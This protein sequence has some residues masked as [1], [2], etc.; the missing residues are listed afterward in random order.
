MDE[1]TLFRAQ[2]DEFFEF[3]PH[4]PLTDEQ[5]AEF[6]GLKYFPVE[7]DLYFEAEIEPFAD[8]KEMLMQTTTG[9]LR[10]F[11]RYGLVHFTV[12]GEPASL[13]VYSNEH[14]FFIPF[15][16]SQAGVET[17]GAGRYLDPEVTDDGKLILDFNMAYNPYCAYNELY[18]CP[19]PPAENR[20]KVAIKAGEKNYK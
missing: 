2:K 16:D 1:Y 18:S 12:E 9:D 5:Q 3:D 7:D 10:T 19:L 17:Y 13:T 4:S 6:E 15:V 14:G 20:L 11:I 8:Q